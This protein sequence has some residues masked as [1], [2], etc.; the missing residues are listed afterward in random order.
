V[1]LLDRLAGAP[2]SWGVCEVP[3]WGLE[4]PRERVLA[5]MHEVGLVGTE[6]GSEGYLPRDPSELRALLARHDLA[7]IGGFVPLVLHDPEQRETT[8]ASA[9]QAASLI[10]AAGAT[11]FVTAAVTSF[12]WDE[13][14]ELTP[15]QWQHVS[16]MLA[17]LD[18]LVAD[19]GLT[20]TLHPH[21]GTIVERADE[22]R[23]VLSESNVRWCLDTGHL[24]IGGYDLLEFLDDAHDRVRHVH[25]KDVHLDIAAQMHSHGV[26]LM[27]AVQRGM[28]CPMGRGDVAIAEVI[29]AL[30]RSGYDGWYVLEQDAALSDGEPPDGGGPKLDILESVAYLRN[31]DTELSRHVE[32]QR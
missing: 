27:Q 32:Q 5:E 2:I 26:S 23:R 28:F 1:T 12:Q 30:E 3:G 22:V 31:V 20:Q 9:R 10:S 11:E 7:L 16:E 13:R 4:L 24:A 21:V 17:V 15:N 6:L 8:L 18:D 19:F 14:R 25:L 29:F